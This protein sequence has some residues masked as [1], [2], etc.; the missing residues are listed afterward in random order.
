MKRIVG[1]I[2]GKDSGPSLIA[3][4]GLHGN[5]IAGVRAAQRVLLELERR[6]GFV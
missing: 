6:R 4:T 1:R 3:M 2:T 5:E